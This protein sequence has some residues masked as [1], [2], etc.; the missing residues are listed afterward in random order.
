[1]WYL[2][3]KDIFLRALFLSLKHAAEQ[4]YVTRKSIL[5]LFFFPE[6]VLLLKPDKY[7]ILSQTIYFS[8]S[9]LSSEFDF[10]L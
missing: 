8:K 2:V 9:G 3:R 6:D 1:M 5:L 10:A 7:Y 4:K